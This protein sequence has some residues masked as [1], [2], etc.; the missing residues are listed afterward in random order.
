MNY[1]VLDSSWGDYV[2]KMEVK[3]KPVGSPVCMMD[4]ADTFAEVASWAYQNNLFT[5][6]AESKNIAAKTST[7]VL[8]KGPTVADT[9]VLS[10][11]G[12]KAYFDKM[13][14]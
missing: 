8:I 12:M 11:P 13:D 1:F 3:R 6:Q 9:A 10:D 4:R 5:I 14:H 7:S 2:Y